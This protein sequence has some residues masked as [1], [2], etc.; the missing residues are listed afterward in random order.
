MLATLISC[1]LVC[2]V[3]APAFAAAPAQQDDKRPPGAPGVRVIVTTLEG[4]VH[5]PGAEVELRQSSDGTVV[6]KTVTDGAGQ[7]MFPDVAPGRYVVRVSRR[8]LV[9]TDSAPFEVGAT[10]I[11]QVLIDTPLGFVAPP[12]EVGAT[13]PSPTDSVQP[14]AMSDMLGGSVI[15]SAPIEGDDFQ[16]LLPLLPGVVRAPDG[17]LRIRGGAPSQ[18]ALQVSSASLNDPS[19]GDFDLQLPGPSIESVEVLANPFAAEYGRFSTSMTVVRTRS[20]TNDWELQPGNLVPRFRKWFSG[21]RSFEPRL[22]VRGPIQRDRTFFA[23]DLQFRH[24]GTPV[25]SLPGE[26]EISLTSLDSFTRI[27]RVMSARHIL[28]GVLITFPREIARTTMDTFRPPEATPD[29]HQTGWSTGVSDRLA[30]RGNLV[31]ENTVAVRR[32]EIEVRAAG[33]SPMVFTPAGTQGAYFNDQERDVTSL[34]WVQALSRTLPWRGEHVVKGGI[35]LQRSVF[36]GVAASRPVEIY[37]ADGS[38]AERTIFA[39]ATEQEVRGTEFSM[40]AQDR[41]RASSRLTFELGLRM[42]R[43]V[44][45]KRVNWSPRAGLALAVLPEG[46]AIVRGGFGK[47]VQR[48]P[49]NVGAFPSFGGRVST[50]FHPDGSVAGAPVALVNTAAPDLRTPEAYVSNIE[51]DQRFARR[52][53]LKIAF[54][55]RRGTN[56]FIVT[57]VPEAGELRLTNGGISRYRELEGT[58]RYIDGARRDVTVSYVWARGTG[59]LNDYDQF[60]G[61]FRNPIIRPNEYSLSPTDVRHRL[62]LRGNI[63]LPGQWDFAPVVELRSGFPWSAIDS[64]RDFVGPR[65]RSGRLPAVHTVDFQLT[66]PWEVRGYRFRAGLKMY[67]ALG[68]SAARDVQSH[69]AASDFGAFY[70]PIERSIGFVLDGAW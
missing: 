16:S 23:Q 27:D 66:R 45:V 36:T 31:L 34:Q 54:L 10:G 7:V 46:R 43:E 25:R 47:F 39:G 18:A 48:T 11:A 14:V 70:N 49:L 60:F 15:A 58:V 51:W 1:L 28:G 4:T 37:R 22:S 44:V 41:W 21:V 3:G 19:T 13:G 53:L 17:R 20:G 33:D 42:D 63:G 9:E 24:V 35:D 26:P 56:E 50:R 38:L 55:H 67:N 64:Y 57:P 52:L 68:A 32:F 8:G 40:F 62:L 12:V 2:L 61:N 30:L 59:D 65:N 29:F 69:V 5:M 6:A